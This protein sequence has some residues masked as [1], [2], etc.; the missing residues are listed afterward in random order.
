VTCALANCSRAQTAGV[1]ESAL[2]AATTV[3]SGLATVLGLFC[4]INS[5][6]LGLTFATLTVHDLTAV[7]D[8]A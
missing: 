1:T 6:V 7:W 3:E 8:V 2:H 5:G 4:E